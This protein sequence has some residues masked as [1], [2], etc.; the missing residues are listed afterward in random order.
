M[1]IPSILRPR[2]RNTTEK[3]DPSSPVSPVSKEHGA[4]V[5]SVVIK[6]ATRLRKGFAL[7]ASIAYVLSW[8][9]LVLVLIGNTYP[10]AVLNSIYFFKL[11]LADIIPMSV[12]NARLINSIAQSIGLHDFYQ[13]GL[14]NFCEGYENV[15]LTYCSEPQTL[16]W[17][18]PVEILMSELL[19]GATIALPTQIITI[20]SVLRI[21]SQIMFGFFFT[22]CILTFFLIFLSPFAVSSKWVSLPLAFTSFLSMMLALSASA[23]AT[24]ISLAFKYAAEAQ[25]ELNIR[26]EVGVKMFAFM[27]LATGFSIW[28]FAVH[29]GMG[30]C[31]VSRRDLRTGRRTIRAGE[32]QRREVSPH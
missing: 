18:N 10:R 30:C 29:A 4:E 13:V 8:I 7:S 9:F 19:A 14:W 25:S 24:A 28:A 31:C 15:G 32:V 3:Y 26:A 27:W 21:S 23:V 2:K 12:P 1:A 16:Y 17:F 11:D 5:N 6:R 22:A 20:L